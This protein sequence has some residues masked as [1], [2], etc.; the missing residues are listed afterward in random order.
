MNLRQTT[1]REAAIRY[2]W[3]KIVDETHAEYSA[4]KGTWTTQRLST[5]SEYLHCHICRIDGALMMLMEDDPYRE[6]LESV[7]L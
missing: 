6:I 3:E 1:A 2:F 7:D 4:Q 5:I